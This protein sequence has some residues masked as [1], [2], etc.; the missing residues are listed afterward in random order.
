[1]LRVVEKFL[2]LLP[3]ASS[4]PHLWSLGLPLAVPP[5]LHRVTQSFCLCKVSLKTVSLLFSILMLCSLFTSSSCTPCCHPRARGAPGTPSAPG[6]GGNTHPLQLH[7]NQGVQFAMGTSPAGK[8]WRNG[9]STSPPRSRSPKPPGAELLG[10]LHT[11]WPD[12]SWCL[13]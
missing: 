7:L 1:M 5:S 13:C 12:D 3:Q 6:L 4:C 2:C 10:P 11:P 8:R 9:H